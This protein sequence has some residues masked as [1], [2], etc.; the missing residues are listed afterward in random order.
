MAIVYKH[1][2]GTSVLFNG[3]D[4]SPVLN[5]VQWDHSADT[6]DTTCFGTGDMTYIA[7]LRTGTVSMSGLWSDDGSGGGST[8]HIDGLFDTALGGSTNVVLSVGPGGAGAFGDPAILAELLATGRTAASPVSGA[9]TTDVAGTINGRTAL[10]KWVAP[11]LSRSSNSV[12]SNGTAVNLNGSTVAETGYIMHLHVVAGT[13]SG[14]ATAELTTTV[15]DSSDASTWV[16]LPSQFAAVS[17]T[18]M[19][20]VQRVVVSTA[21]C[22]DRVRVQHIQ[23]STSLTWGVAMARISV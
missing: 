13:T 3:V 20:H 9:V 1:G 19:N 11:L 6:A 21:A 23:D 2:R 5:D 10:G 12:E 15:Q 18:S 7:G 4:M 17:S 16:D 8:A 22:K 14:D